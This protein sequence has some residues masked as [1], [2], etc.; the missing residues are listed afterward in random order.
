MMRAKAWVDWLRRQ[1]RGKVEPRYRIL[2]VCSG[3]ICRSPTAEGVARHRLR[4]LGLA[5]LIE[6]ESAGIQ[7]FHVGEAPDMRT[8]KAAMARGYDLSRQRA[9]AVEALDYPRFDLLLAMDQ[10]HREALLRRSPPVYQTKVRMF[11]SFVP[12]REEEDVPDP[13]YGAPK[14]FERV[15]DL[16]EEGVAGLIKHLEGEVLRPPES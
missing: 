11:L 13:Y 6:V 9:R 3:N 2:F 5:E 1:G 8:Q 12:G 10:G 4:E 16:C 7:S 14:G 15:L